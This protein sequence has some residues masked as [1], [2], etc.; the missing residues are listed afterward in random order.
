MKSLLRIACVCLALI[1]AS[2]C[3]KSFQD[4]KMTSFDIVSLT[5]RGLSSIDASVEVGV[6]NP[7]VQVTLTRMQAIAKM[8]GVPCLYIF[9]DDLTLAPYTQ[10][11]Y[12][13]DLH[14]TLDEQF[15]PFYLLT[16]IQKPDMDSITV[17]VTF[18]GTLRSGLSK[19]FSY[20]DIPLKD[21]LDKI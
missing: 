13:L 6:D 3:A 8:D 16:L 17:D 18:R 5:P 7:T 20:I 19:D 14:G 11:T 1:A 9:A 10:Q 21:I 4:I 15:N 2:S 12:R